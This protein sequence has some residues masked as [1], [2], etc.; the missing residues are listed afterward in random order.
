MR[1][2]SMVERN[3]DDVDGGLSSSD[4]IALCVLYASVL[5]Q[6]QRSL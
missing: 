3:N 1:S 6:R 4:F 2:H 5:S